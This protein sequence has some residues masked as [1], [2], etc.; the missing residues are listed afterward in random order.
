MKRS[1][2]LVSKTPFVEIGTFA[3]LE[4]CGLSNELPRET[5][6]RQIFLQAKATKSAHLDHY[7][8]LLELTVLCRCF[9]SDGAYSIAC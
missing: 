8:I 9:M 4:E 2:R 6:Y 7:T 3:D 5:R 1:L